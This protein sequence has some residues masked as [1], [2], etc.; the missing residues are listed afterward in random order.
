MTFD[1]HCLLAGLLGCALLPAS[2]A[3]DLAPASD[4]F[5]VAR[6]VSFGIG[7]DPSGG[8]ADV[9][10]SQ[11]SVAPVPGGF[12]VAWAEELLF[13][14]DVENSVVT[15]RLVKSD[16][17]L[18]AVFTA[19]QRDVPT[20]V[21]RVACPSLAPLGAGGFALAWAQDQASGRDLWVQRYDAA[22]AALGAPAAHFAAAGSLHDLPWLAGS[23]TGRN[24]L[25]WSEVRRNARAQTETVYRAAA[26]GASGAAVAPAVELAVVPGASAYRPAAAI[27]RAGRF[28]A[29]WIVP[30]L[31]G[32]GALWAQSFTAAG[33]PLGPP[34]RVGRNAVDGIAMVRSGA[35]VAV[36]WAQRTAAGTRLL[37]ST[38]GLD[39]RPRGTARILVP[40]VAGFASPVLLAAADGSY[41]VAWLDGGH[42]LALH[43][44]ADLAP[45]GAVTGVADAAP[46]LPLAR[47]QGIGAAISGSQ[48]LLAWAG[49]LPA[50]LCPENA[51]RAQLFDITE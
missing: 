42:L 20:A 19:S 13:Q 18:G 38:L 23:V 30:N 43:V 28:T 2:A 17:T 4:S 25:A 34:Q 48:V 10:R 44:G 15:G 29:A 21:R 14:P 12:A 22:G 5:E 33:A 51:V 49:E 47:G 50:G 46:E 3:A 32:S 39:G 9:T 8:A 31:S 16:G 40:T 24:A 7:V 37:A 27:D 35:Q 41:V 1:R 11:V 26:F 45:R 6:E 36:V